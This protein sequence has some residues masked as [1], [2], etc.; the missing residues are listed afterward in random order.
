[1]EKSL[2]GVIETTKN[3][4][5][6][7]GTGLQMLN[8]RWVFG[9][10]CFSYGALVHWVLLRSFAHWG[11]GPGSDTSLVN[12]PLTQLSVAAFGGV[13]VSTLFPHLRRRMAV[14]R[15]H[16]WF[17]VRGGLCGI[18]ATI[19]T[20]ISVLILGSIVLGVT[21]N[22][23]D[24]SVSLFL[25]VYLVMLDMFTYG[26]ALIPYSIPFSF[27]Y[28]CVAGFFVVFFQSHAES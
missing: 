21:L 13:W 15:K 12:H 2:R 27:G 6:R 22:H 16:A 4:R 11:Y 5:E 18:L 17:I 23:G 25:A 24:R 9:L 7:K 19:L 20:L 8:N 3:S 1:M 28:G 26:L 14:Q 10:L